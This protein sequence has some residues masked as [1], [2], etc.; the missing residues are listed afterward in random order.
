M[1]GV[2]LFATF[3]WGFAFAPL[4]WI[5]LIVAIVLVMRDRG[6]GSR[7]AA[8]GREPAI[9]VLGRRFAEGEI[10]L[11]EYR[12]RQAVLEERH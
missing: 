10:N 6:W 8:R 3:G 2:P 1:E 11:Q 9:D 12:E 4:I 5:L 7:P